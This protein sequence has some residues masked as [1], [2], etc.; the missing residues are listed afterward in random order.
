VNHPILSL[1]EME[2]LKTTEYRG[3]RTAVI[4]ATFE[5]MLSKSDGLKDDDDLNQRVMR[6]S[7]KAADSFINNLL[8][9]CRDDLPCLERTK[10]C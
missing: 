6:P 1:E 9:W 10:Y 8:R 3:W 7:D 2:A 4:D 5:V